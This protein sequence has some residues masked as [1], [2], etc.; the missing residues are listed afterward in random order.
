MPFLLSQVLVVDGE[1]CRPVSALHFR[2]NQFSI[3]C[4][5]DGCRLT[6]RGRTHMF[7]N[8]LAGIRYLDLGEL[9]SRV[10]NQFFAQIIDEHRAKLFILF[11]IDGAIAFVAG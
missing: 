6:D 5:K 8:G 7:L 3:V 1:G 4:T 10:E 11:H 2:Y 9:L